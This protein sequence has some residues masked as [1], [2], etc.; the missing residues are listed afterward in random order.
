L[1]HFCSSII[2][3]NLETGAELF[4]TGAMNG[5]C[6]GTPVTTANGRYVMTTHNVGGAK[7]FFSVFD[8]Q[9]ATDA[10]FSYDFPDVEAPFG[11]VG[12]FWDPVAGYYDGGENNG[13]D[14][15]IWGLDASPSVNATVGQIFAFQPPVGSFP[16]NV[17][18][19]GGE[20][21]FVS[22]NPPIITNEGFSMYWA[23]SRSQQRC[24]VGEQGL[25]RRDFGTNGV[26]TVGFARGEPSGAA[27]AAPPTLSSDPTMPFVVGPTAANELFRMSFDFSE[28]TAAPTLL[29]SLPVQNRVLISRDDARVYYTTPAPDGNLYSIDASSLQQIWNISIAAGVVGEIALSLNGDRI[30]VADALGGVTAFIVADAP[31]IT[32][33]PTVS[34]INQTAP[35]VPGT[36]SPAP[37]SLGGGNGT[38]PEPVTAPPVAVA[39]PSLP[40]GNVSTTSPAPSPSP[41]PTM[42]QVPTEAN[43][44]EVVNA[45]DAPVTESE[46]PM[47][48][49]TDAPDA[50]DAPNSTAVPEGES[51]APSVGGNMSEPLPPPAKP[52]VKAPTGSTAISSAAGP[53]GNLVSLFLV[54]VGALVA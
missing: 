29:T 48:N 47:S 24:W 8:T 39:A 12:Y 31:P 9:S 27:A 37:T 46:P 19:V 54:G 38:A 22:P 5:V 6:V 11:A 17:S 20:R 15:F 10:V 49:A 14:I 53:W 34:P 45:T 50:T 51:P 52:P 16:F 35:P 25:G 41:V 42:T 4:S 2:G 33:A 30:Y 28:D 13:N 32:L 36:F 26:N 21:D 43:T 23:V 7:G 40:P 3:I 44:T 18:T 1:I